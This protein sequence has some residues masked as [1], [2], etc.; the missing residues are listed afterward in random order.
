[1]ATRQPRA[2][3]L[4]ASGR[5]GSRARFRIHGGGLRRIRELIH[6]ARA[7]RCRTTNA[8]WRTA[9]SR[10]ACAPAASIRSGSISIALEADDDNAEWEAFVNA[11]TTNLTAFFRESHH[12]PILADFVKRRQQPFVG[13]VLGGIDRR[14]AVFHRDDAD[15]SARRARRAPVHG[16]RPRTST[17][18][19]LA[20]A[21]AGAYSARSGQAPARR[22]A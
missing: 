18:Q 15:R 13:V 10:A 4:G 5:S 14:R 3:E 6:R 7:S 1:M 8:T 21:E 12:F 11:L 22:S 17:A 19:V 9:A 2:I 20:K 16:A